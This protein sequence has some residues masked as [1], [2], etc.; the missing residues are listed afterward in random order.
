MGSVQ[1]E[2]AR[3]LEL[4]ADLAQALQDYLRAAE[5]DKAEARAAYLTKLSAFSARVLRRTARDIANGAG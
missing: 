4:R 2:D 1:A 3:D 5:A